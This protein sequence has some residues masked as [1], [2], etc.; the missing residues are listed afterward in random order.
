MLA[1]A[2]ETAFMSRG[3]LPEVRKAMG[4]SGRGP[5]K[6]QGL[7]ADP[8]VSRQVD[9]R[10]FES[11]SRVYCLLN[12]AI[13]FT[14]LPCESVPVWVTVR[15]LPSPDTTTFAV[16]VTFPPFFQVFS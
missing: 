5:R 11:L 12:T 14:V 9:G 4:R 10:P 7:A 2:P 13:V 1:D 15:V 8:T 6:R 16:T 3:V